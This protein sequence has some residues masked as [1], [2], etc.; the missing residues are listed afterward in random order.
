MYTLKSGLK[1]QFAVC[2]LQS[3]LLPLSELSMLALACHLF[4]L[5]I[6]VSAEWQKNKNKMTIFGSL[7]KAGK[8]KWK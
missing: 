3:D 1:K 5:R 6:W 4:S 7:Y 8:L 2:F